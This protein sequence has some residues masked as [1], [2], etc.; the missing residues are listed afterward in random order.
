MRKFAVL[1]Q[2]GVLSRC[3]ITCNEI[4][5]SDSKTG[6]I[7]ELIRVCQQ[8]SVALS[9]RRYCRTRQDLPGAK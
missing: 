7:E 5:G 4:H 3:S 6:I 1:S 2:P 8:R 9:W